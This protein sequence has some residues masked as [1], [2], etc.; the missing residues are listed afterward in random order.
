[1]QQLIG[2][3][4]ET[5]PA[6]KIHVTRQ[7]DGGEDSGHS[8][9]QKLNAAFLI[10]LCGPSHP[11]Y[12]KAKTFLNHPT[13]D[14]GYQDIATFYNDGIRLIQNEL[15]EFGRKNDEVSNSLDQLAGWLT[16]PGNPGVGKTQGMT[17]KFWRLFF[18]EGI[19]GLGHWNKAVDQLR[20]ERAVRVTR[21]NPDP[22]RHPAE[23]ILFTSNILLT[24]PGVSH[25]IGDLPLPASV[26]DG[27]Q[28]ASREPQRYW[29]DHPVPIGVKP[30][31]NEILHG[32]RGLSDSLEFEQQRGVVKLKERLSCLLSVS[33]THEGL[34]PITRTYLKETLRTGANLKGMDIYAFTERDSR[35]LLDEVILPAVERY[36]GHE[37]FSTLYEIIGIDGEYG[38]HY[39]FLK[40]VSAVWKI[41]I[42]PGIKATFKIDL[43]QVFP[44]KELV[45]ETG[46]SAFEHLK[47]PLWGAEGL[48]Q[49]G[50]KIELG[51]LAGALVNQRDIS[52]SVFTP[53]V[54]PPD[55]SPKGDEMIF[56]SRMP[57]AL[58]T[59]AEMMTRYGQGSL[60]GQTSCLHRIHVTGGTNGI[61]I[62]A[63]RKH[64]PFTPVFIGR[65]EDQAYLMS[66]LFEN[67][68]G[69]LRVLHKDGLIMRHDKESIAGEAIRS[70]ALG[71]LIGD[72][73]R[74]LSFSFY[75]RALPWTLKEIKGLLDPFTGCFI[76]RIPMTVV[77]LKIALKAASFFE[78][79]TPEAEHTGSEFI[80]MAARRLH[81]M[82]LDLS[83][84][85]NPLIERYH[86]EKE[87]WNLFF[88]V[89]DDIEQ[90]LKTGEAFALDLQGKAKTLAADCMIRIG[91][92]P[93]RAN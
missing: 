79:S 26:R 5:I 84:D 7:F 49:Q 34:Q 14:P 32:L 71:K 75:A 22:I 91:S 53:D 80:E 2:N 39:T 20:K 50:R 70:A 85:P 29:Y 24:T 51:M 44:Q 8:T 46:A 81:K 82:V 77:Y 9:A 88:D 11:D 66:V 33:V 62:N 64:R 25:T 35:R 76:S 10:I 67:S 15:S 17:K 12:K 86:Q 31:N 63:L 68:D 55:H 6:G 57:Q 30:E 93:A 65:A 27:L 45:E 56:F 4:P 69:Y 47:T 1:M 48:D 59:E 60:D 41:L 52:N 89:L 42:N 92:S 83:G 38:R 58:S 3:N 74:I 21:L 36:K 61:L 72:Y 28:R 23:E 18:P 73:A 78:E 13:L 40:A 37:N 54:S 43:D 19:A 87:T 90:G 16:R